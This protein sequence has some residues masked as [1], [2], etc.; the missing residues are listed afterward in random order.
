MDN[1]TKRKLGIRSSW[2]RILQGY[3]KT[4]YNAHKPRRP[5]YPCEIIFEKTAD[6]GATPTPP[7]TLSFHSIYIT[8]Y[9]NSLRST[10]M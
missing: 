7:D 2:I 4:T 8:S 1:L 10:L 6:A 5:R 9:L 3:G